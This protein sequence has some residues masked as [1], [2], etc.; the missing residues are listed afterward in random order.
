MLQSFFGLQERVSCRAALQ[1]AQKGEETSRV[2]RSPALLNMRRRQLQDQPSQAAGPCMS[3]GF[4]DYWERMAEVAQKLAHS[5]A[6]D[7]GDTLDIAVRVVDADR[8]HRHRRVAR[9]E[10]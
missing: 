2:T 5:R 9:V 10:A 3:R 4:Q 7:V 8:V 6:V 1:H